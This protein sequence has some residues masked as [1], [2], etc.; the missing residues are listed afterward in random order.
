MPIT[1]KTPKVIRTAKQ[2]NKVFWMIKNLEN[3]VTITSGHVVN[4]MVD[5]IINV[6]EKIQNIVWEGGLLTDA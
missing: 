1:V 5:H 2:R 3:L 6:N 4:Y